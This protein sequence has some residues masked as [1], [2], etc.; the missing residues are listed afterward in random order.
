MAYGFY[1]FKGGPKNETDWIW[2]IAS[3][4]AFRLTD[5]TMVTVMDVCR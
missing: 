4:Y 2:Y 5:M 1:L 3:L